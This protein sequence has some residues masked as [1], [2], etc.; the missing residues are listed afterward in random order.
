[1]AG[2]AQFTPAEI[3]EVVA[4]RSAAADIATHDL[5][6]AAMCDTVLHLVDGR[7]SSGPA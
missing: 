2:Q 7:V 3:L 4:E 5:D 6:L 1:M